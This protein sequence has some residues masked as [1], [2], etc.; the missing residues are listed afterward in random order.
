MEVLQGNVFHVCG[1]QCYL[2]FQPSAD[3][4]WQSWANNEL[5]QATTFPSP[6]A[7]ETC[8]PWGLPLG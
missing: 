3:M 2:E 8:V 1:K 5:S 4:S 6:Y 7:N